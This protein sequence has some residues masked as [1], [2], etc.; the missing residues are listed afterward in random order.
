MENEESQGA[1][2]KKL[3]TLLRKNYKAITNF[4]GVTSAGVGLRTIAGQ[5]TDEI[6]LYVEVLKKLP[7]SAIPKEQIIPSSIEGIHIDVVEKRVVEPAVLRL[8]LEEAEAKAK[9]HGLDINAPLEGGIGV[10]NHMP[11]N[12]DHWQYGTLGAMVYMDISSNNKFPA[13]LSNQ[14]VLY[15]NNA[16]NGQA[17]YL[18]YGTKLIAHNYESRNSGTEIDAAV[19][20]IEDTITYSNKIIGIGLLKGFGDPEVNQVVRKYGFASSLTTG[21]I[22]KVGLFCDENICVYTGL[23]IVCVEIILG[24]P[25]KTPARRFVTYGDSGSVTVSNS[26]EVLGLNWAISTGDPNNNITYSNDV[27]RIQQLIGGTMKIPVP[28][29]QQIS[30]NLINETKRLEKYKIELSKSEKG[31]EIL[32]AFMEYMEEGKTLISSHRD[33]KVT[34]HRSMGCQFIDL[35]AGLEDSQPFQF[36]RQV[37]GVSI[38]KFITNMSNAFQLHG[39]KE[40][41]EASKNVIPYLLALVEKHDTLE[42]IILAISKDNPIT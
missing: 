37:G 9:E 41:S 2:Q 26:N 12:P 32:K 6:G 8:T 31:R 34:W 33:C 30:Q 42:E 25:V 27:R 17:I 11:A 1:T 29:A 18:S 15:A 19:A 10:T 23:E 39:S 35:P 20:K 21:Q 22:T 3:E 38:A 13:I 16:G 4:E 14:H 40:I 36:K 28:D 24:K 7:L 5:Y